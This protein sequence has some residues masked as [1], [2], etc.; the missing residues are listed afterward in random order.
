MFE[1]GRI[2]ISFS[3]IFNLLC[4]IRI[5]NFQRHLSHSEVVRH[6]LLQKRNKNLCDL[7]AKGDVSLNPTTH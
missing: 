7:A 4:V 5:Y 3:G 6:P 2:I 1:I